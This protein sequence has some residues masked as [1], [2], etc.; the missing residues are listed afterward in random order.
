LAEERAFWLA[1][2]QIN[3]VGPIL[4]K[5]LQQHFVKLSIAWEADLAALVKVEGLG[6]QTAEVVLNERQK[7]EPEQ[8]LSEYL[9]KN[10]H[11]WTPADPGYPRLLLEIPDPPPVLH[12]RGS[13][14]PD[15]NHGCRPTIA[16]IGTRHPSEYGRR[17]TRKLS[18]LLAEKGFSVV[19]GLAEGV[20][21]EAHRSCL[22]AGGRTIAVLGT[23][24]D[25]VYPWSN[26]KLYEQI[27]EQGLALSE[28]PAGTQPDRIHFPR[29][30]RIVAGLCRAVL[31][32]EAPMKSGAL[33]TAHLANDYGRD[34]YALPGSLYN[35]RVLGCLGLLNK[36]AQVVLGEAH[37]LELLGTMPP[38]NPSVAPEPLQLPI[39]DLDPTLQQV[40]QALTDLSNQTAEASFDR[41]VQQAGLA[42]GTVSGALLQLEMM[43]LVSSLP[44]MR[45][46]RM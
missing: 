8:L 32:T 18:T 38:L 14:Q 34:V 19:S 45:Y 42:A 31:V 26:R 29:R 11:F 20:D 30:N 13:V 21:A 28:Y 27:L 40:L 12:Y 4:L 24:V 15:E 10:P 33:I 46:Q 17:W 16:I 41:I 22:T 43:D 23:G 2:S 39:V 3:G 44:G 5:R 25:I 36:G 1:W 6:I 37:L 9:Q 7:L 35:S